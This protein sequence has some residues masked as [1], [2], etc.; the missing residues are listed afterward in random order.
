MAFC[1]N[2]G[3]ELIDGVKFCTVCGA[4]TDK[5]NSLGTNTSVNN[6]VQIRYQ[7]RPQ[8]TEQPEPAK[9]TYENPLKKKSG[10]IYAVILFF[11]SCFGLFAAPGIVAALLAIGIIVGAVI[12]FRKGYKFKLLTGMAFIIAAL[13]LV[14]SVN[15]LV[16][17]SGSDK[18]D[19]YAYESETNAPDYTSS[20]SSNK[21]SQTS[22]ATQDIKEESVK[23]TKTVEEEPEQE[24]KEEPAVEAGLDPDLKAF[25]DSYEAY[26]DE[27]VEFMKKY[28][29]D[30]GNAISM[31]DDYTKMMKRY[32]DFADKV[33]KYDTDTMSKADLEYYLDV[34]NRCNKKLL[35]V[36]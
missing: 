2:C 9:S 7:Q 12:C 26:I 4:P 30:P 16:N 35:S 1:S 18:D 32:A 22:V 5:S 14:I 29:S 31:M 33:D 10:R 27:Y 36:Y 34:T 19:M 15:G 3:H 8:V 28:S 13:A 11:V 6:E 17:K 23:E 25:L 20:S 21:N 24:V